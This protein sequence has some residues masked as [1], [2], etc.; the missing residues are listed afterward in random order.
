M[1][2]FAIPAPVLA[3]L[4]AFLCAAP[5][6]A[7]AD[8]GPFERFLGQGA[9]DCVPLEAIAG[10]STVTGLNDRQFEFVRALYVA[11]PPVSRALP[12][13]DRAVIAVA[14]DEALLALISDGEA[15]ARFLAPA[16]IRDMLNDVGAG[17]ARPRGDPT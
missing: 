11:L 6:L 10:V 16:F 7:N 13:G 17:K 2:R 5:A 14:G 8:A 9:P 15:C 1:N 3:T 12:P 4:A